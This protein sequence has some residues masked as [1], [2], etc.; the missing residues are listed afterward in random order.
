[1]LDQRA[2]KQLSNLN[3][4]CNQL[5]EVGC[6]LLLLPVRTRGDINWL[7]DGVALIGDSIRRAVIVDS[8]I[9]LVCG[10]YFLHI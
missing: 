2:V 1:M 3:V 7:F 10:W 8:I 9:T 4:I 5:S 6:Y